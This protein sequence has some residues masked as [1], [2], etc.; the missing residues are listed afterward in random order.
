MSE[1]VRAIIAVTAIFGSVI[2]LATIG[3]WM[4]AMRNWTK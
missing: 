4:V 1:R 2:L 3:W